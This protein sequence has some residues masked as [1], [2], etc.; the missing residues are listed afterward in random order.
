MADAARV[1]GQG[2]ATHHWL[3][4]RMTAGANLVLM[5]W[6]MISILL[7]P[8]YDFATLT[9]WIAQPFVVVPMLLLI[10]TTFYHFTLGVQVVID[11]YQHNETRVVLLVLL[12]YFAYAAGALGLFSIL[13]IAL[14]AGTGAI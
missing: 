13:K 3:Q 5:L 7:L 1:T 8:A 10:V 4:Q 11:D 14:T 2:E 9:A 6:F 12:N